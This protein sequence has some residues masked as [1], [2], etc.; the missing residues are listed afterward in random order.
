MNVFSKGFSKKQNVPSIKNPNPW[1]GLASYEDPEVAKVH[2]KFCGRDDESYDV[3]KLITNNIFVTLYGKSGIGKTSLLNAGV[4]PELR[5]FNYY[6]FYLRLCSR[7]GLSCSYQSAII[8]AIEQSPVR[9]ETTDIIDVQGNEHAIDFLWNYFARH[10]FY[11]DKN[12][13]VIPV[14]VIDQFE[15]LFNS[16]TQQVEILLRQIDYINDKDHVLDDSM[17]D[18]KVYS[19]ETN[20][21]FVVS[22]R[23]DDLYKLEDCLSSCFLPALKRCRYRLQGLSYKGAKDAVLLPCKDEEIFDKEF[24]AEIADKIIKLSSSSDR[25]INTL[26]LSLLCYV[27]YNDSVKHNRT[28]KLSDLDGYKGIL[29]VYYLNIV[30]HLPKSQREYIEDNLI[31]EYGRRKSIYLTE[32]QIHAPLAIEYTKNSD[33]RFLNIHDEQ[34]ELI[35]DQLASII[36]LYRNRRIEDQRIRSIAVSL[37]S[38]YVVAAYIIWQ[39]LLKILYASWAIMSSSLL[40][41]VLHITTDKTPFDMP[42]ENVQY[43][44]YSQIISSISLICLISYEVPKKVCE[45]FYST[46]SVKKLLTIISCVILSVILGTN[47]MLGISLSINSIIYPLIGWIAFIVVCLLSNL[48][49]GSNENKN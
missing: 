27:L 28:I 32:L 38:Y 8:E 30:N 25:N 4:F 40:D 20:Y 26:M 16:N 9:I 46:M 12:E 37:L 42:I 1:A 5:L 3:A 2:L 44:V 35:H 7:E 18:E 21:R 13:K 47:W 19:Y 36:L 22:I 17:V 24:E 43:L 15:E 39:I 31:D 33:R 48:K 29:E 49:Q 6:P 11:N 34:V 10:R 23:E 41:Y 45:Y 14:I